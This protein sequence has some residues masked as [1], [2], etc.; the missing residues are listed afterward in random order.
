MPA[1]NFAHVDLTG[2]E[3]RPEQH[4]GGVYRRQHGLGF[5]PPLELFVQTFDCIRCP[6]A[7]PLARR[8]SCEGEQPVAGF[9]QAVGDGAVFEPPLADEGFAAS[10]DV[11]WRRRIDHVAVVGADLLVQALGSMGEQVAVLVNCAPLRRHAVPD[12]RN[13]LVV[14]RR[15][16]DDE[17]LG[18]TQT[19]LDEIVRTA[20]QA[21]V[22]SRPYS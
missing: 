16:V 10:L 17:E 18:L 15:A 7:A 5:D 19:A 21:S 14:P 13:R 11:L 20:R 4:G 3:Q 22:L 9:L 8:Q 6:R 12:G 1:I 2:R